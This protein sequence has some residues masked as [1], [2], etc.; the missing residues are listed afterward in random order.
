M[1]KLRNPFR[2]SSPPLPTTPAAVILPPP[3]PSRRDVMAKGADES[4]M[5]PSPVTPPFDETLTHCGYCGRP[6]EW[7]NVVRPDGVRH[8]YGCPSHGTPEPRTEEAVTARK[9]A[10]RSPQPWVTGGQ[11]TGWHYFWEEIPS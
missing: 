1:K 2:A 9:V 6:M 11:E 10:L 5:V 3:E 7:A 4:Q 8:V